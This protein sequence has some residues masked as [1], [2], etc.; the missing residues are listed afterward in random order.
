MLIYEI[1]VDHHSGLTNYIPLS[2]TD[3]D[4]KNNYTNLDW[5]T[6]VTSALFV[7]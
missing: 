2:K 6:E 7:K 4:T 3:M 5:A 1:K